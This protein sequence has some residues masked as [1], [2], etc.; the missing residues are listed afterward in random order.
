M[1]PIP[2][3]HHQ[4]NHH[5][6][7]LH[8][9]CRCGKA[10]AT[11]AQHLKLIKKPSDSSLTLLV[12]AVVVN[13][14]AQRIRQR[15]VPDS[16]WPL[17][18]FYR[19]TAL[20]PFPFL[21]LFPFIGPLSR[22]LT[23][24]SILLLLSYSCCCSASTATVITASVCRNC[25]F[26][27]TEAWKKLADAATTAS[28]CKLGGSCEFVVALTIIRERSESNGSVPLCAAPSGRQ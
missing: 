20:I 13:C 17:R 9:N 6:H 10:A 19:L 24:T 21:A 11:A 25:L 4:H 3:H 15:G 14:N 2:H 28:V 27:L 5:H 18:A 22:L 7:R 1:L 23:S 26:V 12:T 16:K 8:F